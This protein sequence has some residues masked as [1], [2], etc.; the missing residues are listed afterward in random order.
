MQLDGGDCVE[1]AGLH[2][3]N[4]VENIHRAYGPIDILETMP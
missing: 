2:V 4:C 3:Y 1:G